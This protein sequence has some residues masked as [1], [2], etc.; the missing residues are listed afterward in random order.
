MAELA[1]LLVFVVVWLAM[2]GYVNYRVW[3][4]PDEIWRVQQEEQT[5]AP[6]APFDFRRFV[7]L[8]APGLQN[9]R[10]RFIW[11]QR[12]VAAIVLLLGIVMLAGVLGRF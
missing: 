1:C 6:E 2:A 7:H 8:D 4:K 11:M 12:A 10:G 9:H 3:R 5:P